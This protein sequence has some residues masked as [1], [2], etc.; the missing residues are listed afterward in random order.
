MLGLLPP[1]SSVMRLLVSAAIFMICRPP[2]VE[3]VNEILSTP[4]WRTN[5]APAL[6]PPPATTLNAPA[7]K[8]AS[9]THSADNS[10]VSGVSEAGFKTIVHPGASARANFQLGMLS[11]KVHR[12][13]APTQP[14]GSCA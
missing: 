6:D 5:A 4:G 1:S 14:I 9:W 12:P 2:S 10:A 8:P 7:G 13:I 3:P 11:R